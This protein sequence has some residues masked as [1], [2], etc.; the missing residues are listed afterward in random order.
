MTPQGESL[1]PV[2]VI[3]Y[4]DHSFKDVLMNIPPPKDREK[5]TTITGSYAHDV[6]FISTFT[7]L[8]I[9]SLQSEKRSEESTHP[10]V[11]KLSFFK[12]NN[13]PLKTLLA[14]VC[15]KYMFLISRVFFKSIF[16]CVSCVN[17]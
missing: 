15:S 1:S 14:A 8:I 13:F 16:N 6:D 2:L 10:C 5:K 4:L 12:L 11:T 17:I 3:I 9:I 7:F